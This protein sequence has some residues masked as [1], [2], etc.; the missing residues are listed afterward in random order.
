MI[1]ELTGTLATG[2][3]AIKIDGEDGVARFRLVFPESEFAEAI[4]IPAYCAGREFQLTIDDFGMLAS[5][6]RMAMSIDSDRETKIWF[7]TM[8]LE[9]VVALVKRCRQKPL[10][11]KIEV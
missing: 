2:S 9:A 3:A 5:L 4:K 7:E 1:I 11:V 10:Q 6:P 8:N